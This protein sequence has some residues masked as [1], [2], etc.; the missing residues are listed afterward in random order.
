MERAIG[1]SVPRVAPASVAT[2]MRGTSLGTGVTLPERAFPEPV[3]NEVSASRRIAA[4]PASW[5]GSR[6]MLARPASLWR[7][8]RSSTASAASGAASTLGGLA[9]EVDGAGP[10]MAGD[11]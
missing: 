11:S 1:R 9:I 7:Y 5:P 10:T 8:G 6:A 4:R 3:R 2:G